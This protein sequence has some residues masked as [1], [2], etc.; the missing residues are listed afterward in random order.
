MVKIKSSSVSVPANTPAVLIHTV[1]VPEGHQ[2]DFME[3]GFTVPTGTSITAYVEDEKVID[4]KRVGDDDVRRIVLNWVV[5]P[6][7]EVRVYGANTT[8][9]AL[10]VG[11]TL[12][13]DDISRG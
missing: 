7:T 4:Y 12:V 5:M 1:T 2:Y 10:T 3:T 6:G 11:N 13:Y 8:G 9:G